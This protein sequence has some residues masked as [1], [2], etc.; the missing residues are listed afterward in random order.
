MIVTLSAGYA[1][2]CLRIESDQHLR[3]FAWLK[4]RQ[5]RQRPTYFA[6]VVMTR[7]EK[8]IALEQAKATG[9]EVADGIG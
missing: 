4:R 8:V 6:G 1:G 7:R 3:L 2:H 9:L 5:D